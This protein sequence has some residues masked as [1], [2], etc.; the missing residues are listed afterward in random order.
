MKAKI[1]E[2]CSTMFGLRYFI[3]HLVKLDL[4][5]KFRRSKLGLLWT[6]VSPLCLTLI[7]AVV[8]GTAFKSDIKTYAPYILSGMLFWDIMSSSFTGGSSA[9][10]ANQPYIRQCAHPYSLYTLKTAIG[11]IITF[12]IATLSLVCW[13]VF[14]NPLGIVYGAIFFI[15]AV[16]VYFMLSWAGTTIA[17]YT[18]VK[19]RD[20]PMMAPLILQALW[21]VSPVF[22]QESMFQSNRYLY[23][24]FSYNPITRLLNLIRRPFLYNQAPALMDYGISLVFVC[25]LAL[26]AY[27]I[28]KKNGK[29][30]IFYL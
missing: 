2:Y 19:Y 21:Y 18:N 30:I 25:I 3:F 14:I 17:A 7:M 23:M 13:M 4:K 9:I 28:S 1:K 22:L 20:Y 11:F 5:N 26:L 24:L 6:F 16:L 8:F 10:I 27:R 15:P 29:E 12:M